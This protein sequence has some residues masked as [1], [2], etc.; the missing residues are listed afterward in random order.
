MGKVL[1]LD[2]QCDK[3]GIFLMDM[4]KILPVVLKEAEKILT[5]GDVGLLH[6]FLDHHELGTAIEFICD[7]LIDHNRIIP[8]SLALKIQFISSTLGLNPGKTWWYLL[9]END[10]SHE[11]VRLF[12][13]GPD[14]LSPLE[15]IFQEYRSK[16]DIKDAE[17]I[18]EFIT[19][20]EIELAIDL[21]CYCLI[22]KKIPIEKTTLHR[23]RTLLLDSERDPNAWEGFEIKEE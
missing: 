9:V 4:D 17:Q 12:R 3:K 5:A 6:E 1:L 18:D 8:E 14:I 21:L 23:I 22:K 2:T 11:P 13:E 10:F 16:I 19:Q 15:K 7:Q 20:N